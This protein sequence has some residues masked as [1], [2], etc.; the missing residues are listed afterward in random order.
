LLKASASP[1][2]RLASFPA[3]TPWL[4]AFDQIVSVWV[5]HRIGFRNLAILGGA[6]IEFVAVVLLNV[7]RQSHVTKPGIASIPPDGT[8]NTARYN[9]HKDS[10]AS[11]RNSRCLFP[12]I[13]ASGAVFGMTYQVLIF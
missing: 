12:R 1:V 11:A 10:L 6:L 4:T 8:H 5:R 13:T 3:L 7:V 9:M 2:E